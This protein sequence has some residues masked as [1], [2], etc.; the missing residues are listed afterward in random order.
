M[1]T[2]AHIVTALRLDIS[3]GR[4]Q[5][6]GILKYI[7]RHGKNWDI[8]L[9]TRDQL[10]NTPA[11]AFLTDVDGIIASESQVR[12]IANRISSCSIPTVLIDAPHDI[13]KERKHNIALVSLDNQAIGEMGAS[14]FFLRGRATAYAFVTD[15]ECRPWAIQRA[16]AFAKA[17][18]RNKAPCQ[19][20]DRPD[21]SVFQD[22]L[23]AQQK[24]VAV[25][26]ACDRRLNDIMECCRELKLDI[27]GQVLILGV[28]NDEMYCTHSDPSLS[29]I[30]PGLEREGAVAAE[31]LDRILSSKRLRRRSSV[32]LRP[33]QVFDREST[34]TV[35]PAAT[36]IARG[37]A[38]IEGNANKP[39]G[40]SDVVAAMGVSRRLADLRFRQLK[41]TSISSAIGE[42]R[43]KMVLV[44]A[45]SSR[46]S[47]SELTKSCGF[48]NRRQL[49]RLFKR[50][51]GMSIL[52]WRKQQNKR[53]FC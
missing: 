21:L 12:D 13:L 45:K 40:V 14:H 29:S 32:F 2:I 51:T 22:W 9:R 10:L 19:I 38:F 24:P 39:I 50:K 4:E 33:V 15:K 16:A 43:M 30:D 53:Q 47:I 25:M 49:E 44:K 37:I 41:G 6:I 46:C 31:R 17:V 42:T 35:L 52:Q 7:K 8:Q 1:G 34:S 23:Q 18:R 11:S 28:D 27:P 20:F 26:A 36:L 5:L 48:S 3:P